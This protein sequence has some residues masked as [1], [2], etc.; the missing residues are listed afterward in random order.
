M[1]HYL[2]QFKVSCIARMFIICYEVKYF[3]SG[4]LVPMKLWATNKGL[5]LIN[6]INKWVGG[7][8]Y[9][10][11]L[12]TGLLTKNGLPSN[13]MLCSSCV[14]SGSCTRISLGAHTAT[15]I[16]STWNPWALPVGSH[17]TCSV[18]LITSKFIFRIAFI[19]LVFIRICES[20]L[21]C[22]P[23]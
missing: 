22:T 3:L 23:K 2:C 21:A 10:Y 5:K 4:S 1:Q 11:T 13:L 17:S 15:E 12:K 20:P 6:K 16:R 14:Q 9:L 19:W 7:G 18:S 8:D